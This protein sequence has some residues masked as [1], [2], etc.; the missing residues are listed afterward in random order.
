MK[1]TEPKD[2][3]ENELA[4]VLM[5]ALGEPGQGDADQSD[6]CLWEETIA[7]PAK[8]L[9][10]VIVRRDE[11]QAQ[12]PLCDIVREKDSAMDALTQTDAADTLVI[13]TLR[14][15]LEGEVRKRI[16]LES[17]LALA[18]DL[19][20]ARELEIE[21]IYARHRQREEELHWEAKDAHRRTYDEGYELGY[22]AAAD[23]A[24]ERFEKLTG[25]MPKKKGI[26]RRTLGFIFYICIGGFLA[27]L[28][29]DSGDKKK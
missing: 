19:A 23:Y 18:R 14:R 12:T 17:D 16:E 1:E 4:T 6:E 11:E 21:R 8:E 29:F 27:L 9:Q 25:N 13:A 26:I 5:G 2:T 24:V 3:V 15:K 20:R 22:A 28:F 10:S 7:A